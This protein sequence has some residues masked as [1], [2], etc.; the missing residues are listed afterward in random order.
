MRDNKLA[1]LI[2]LVLAM[3]FFVWSFTGS[4]DR[5]SE[6]LAREGY[7]QVE[8]TGW[9]PFAFWCDSKAGIAQGFIAYSPNGEA[10][11]GYVCTSPFYSYVVD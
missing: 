6:K 3:G 8:I 7:T 4:A 5:A 10:R 9:K 11:Q 1:F 2:G